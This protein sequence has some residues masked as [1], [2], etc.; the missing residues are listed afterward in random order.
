MAVRTFHI[1]TVLGLLIGRALPPEGEKGIYAIVG[2]LSEEPISRQNLETSWPQH[3]ANLAEQLPMLSNPTVTT[4][5]EIFNCELDALLSLNSRLVADVVQNKQ[6]GQDQVT[7]ATSWL[8]MEGGNEW[9]VQIPNKRPDDTSQAY[10]LTTE[11]RITSYIQKWLA[12]FCQEFG[13]PEYL[14]IR[15][16]S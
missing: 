4:R 9:Q 14:E 13:I 7:S 3:A 2:F 15:N 1:G 5:L 16:N 10:H 6:T 8:L 11:E 12:D